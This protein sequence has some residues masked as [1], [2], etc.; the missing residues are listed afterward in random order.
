[1]EARH[2]NT[3]SNNPLEE[4]M[5]NEPTCTRCGHSLTDDPYCPSHPED[6]NLGHRYE[7]Q[8]V[9]AILLAPGMRIRRGK[10]RGEVLSVEEAFTPGR[11]KIRYLTRPNLL[12]G[13]SKET[14][15]F[16]ADEFAEIELV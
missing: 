4:A 16:V 9:E 12:G 5:N 13:G 15:T 11:L 14:W 7:G 6:G 2:N 1:M 3:D 10:H 8:K